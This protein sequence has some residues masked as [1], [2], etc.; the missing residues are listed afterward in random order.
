MAHSKK[1]TERVMASISG[2]MDVNSKAGGIKINNMDS[3][4]TKA[5][6]KQVL[7]AVSGKWE[8]V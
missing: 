5:K 2:L 3:V 6:T 1:I 7:S 8:S 4:C